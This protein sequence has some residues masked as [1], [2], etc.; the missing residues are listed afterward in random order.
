M[1]IMLLLAALV[2]GGIYGFQ[3]FRNKMI[4]KAIKGQGNPPQAVSTIVAQTSTWQPTVEAVGNLRA[5]SGASLAAEVGGLVTG[6]HFES[7][8]M[9][10]AGQLLVELNAAP[11]KAQL[12]QLKAAAM[13]AQQNHE[14]DS[15]QLKV[16]AVSQAVVDADAANLKSAQAQVATQEATIAQK[17][18]LA[19]FAG[20]LGIRQVDL[21]QFLAAGTT[22]VNLQKLDPMYLDFTV[23][24]AQIDLIRVGNKITIQT[25][26]LPDKTFIGSISA[27]E[28]QV[29]TATR[30]LKVR[31]RIANP[32][33]ELL[34]GLF[35]TARVD[36][37]GKRQ[38][39]TL[40]DSA[41]AYNTYGST[42]FIVK[43]DGKGADGK[44]KLS[45]GQRFVTTG[46]TRGDQVA[47]LTGLKAGETVVTAGQLKLRN[48]ASVFINNSVQP[49]NNP[50]PEV[51]DE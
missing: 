7:G 26:A 21:G 50:N 14:R 5:A 13:L 17:T 49:A 37:G 23:P 43:D 20:R 27:I 32:K 10:K 15:A 24:Q 22:I 19:P 1:I 45:V 30:N 6:I 12:E 48:G 51:K 3:Q 35:A 2:F 40:P 33:G 25:N 4:Q 44:P 34:P 38:Y 9:V 8:E 11:L 42:V 46:A 47:V 28:P 36:E 29:D 31:A 18:I 41:I 16:Q 39:I